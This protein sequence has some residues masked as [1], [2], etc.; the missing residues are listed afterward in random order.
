MATDRPNIL[1]L[2]F[3][4]TSPRF[5]CF[6]DAVA[7]TP[8]IDRLASEGCV[9]PNNF[10]TAPVS[11]PARAAVIT[12]MYAATI[13]AH[14]M[15][16]TTRN[17]YTAGMP[18]PYECVPP[19]YV[20]MVP[21]YLRAAGYFCTNNQKTDYQFEP[22]ITAWDQWSKEAH[23]RNRADADQPF[24]AV[25][26]LDWTHESRM[27]DE[28]WEGRE[29]QTD[30]ARVVVPP[31][32][33][34]TQRVRLAIAR[35][36]DNVSARDAQAGELLKQLDE[37]GLADNT[38]VFVWSDHGEGLPRHKRWPYDSGLR[39]PMVVRWPGGLKAGSR[40]ERLVSTIDLGPTVLS[41]CGVDV[42]RHMQGVPFIGPQAQRRE[43]AFATRDRYDEAYD[44]VRAVRDERYR[45]IRHAHPGMS[46]MIWNPYRNRHP[47]MQEIWRLA[48]EDKLVGP[49][50]WFTSNRPAEEL[51]D[52]QSDP[53]EINNLAADR[54]HA[55]TLERLRGV[56]DEWMA[57]CDRFAD[58]DEAE[59]VRR[60]WPGG[61][62]P[63][64]AVPYVLA[65][66]EGQA[67]REPLGAHA[68][69]KGPTMIQ[70]HCPTQ[71][72][73]MQYSINGQPAGGTRYY[74]GAWRLSEPGQYQIMAQAHRIGFKP[75]EKIE[76]RLT[77]N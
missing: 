62:Q 22:A 9:F 68:T 46:Y 59:M 28:H 74:T 5:G 54:A 3:E 61:V 4:D 41:L 65:L 7:R 36:Y 17:R 52:T 16:T 56:M 12:G 13:G 26:N 60:W 75:S 71:G 66:G 31:Y 14:H 19:H 18:M 44:Q 64:T 48:A 37:D 6:G 57:R 35:L 27:W 45:Y 67:G 38:I 33:P 73:S 34:D 30:P 77:V 51:Y 10:S 11:A 39:V 63:T 43:Y 50:K 42:P 15:R 70:L 25:F 21:Q 23:W 1:W 53:H 47:V 29:P 72:A 55:K 8:N 24:F 20:K 49:Q 32:L 2:S 40:D 58:V 69:V 76:I